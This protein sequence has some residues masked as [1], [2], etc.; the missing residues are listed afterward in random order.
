MVKFKEAEKRKFANVFVCRNCKQKQRAPNLK[1]LAGKITC[2][3][4]GAH[5]FRPVRRK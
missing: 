2:K 5:T 4:C 1:V 3:R